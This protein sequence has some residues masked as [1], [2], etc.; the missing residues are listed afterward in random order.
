MEKTITHWVL[1]RNDKITN[2]FSNRKEGIIYLRKLLSQ[3]LKDLKSQET[4]NEF[5]YPIN[6]SNIILKE[7]SERKYYLGL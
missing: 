6:F 1:I 2:I 5:D 3:S 7:I 4:T